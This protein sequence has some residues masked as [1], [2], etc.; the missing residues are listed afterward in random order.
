MKFINYIFLMICLTPQIIFS[1]QE[2]YISSLQEY[3]VAESTPVIQLQF[4]YN[5]L[6][7]YTVTGGS[8]ITGLSTSGSGAVVQGTGMAFLRTNSGS[9]VTGSAAI[10]ASKA[11]LSYQAGAGAEMLFSVIFG[12]GVTGNKQYVGIGNARDG[13]FFGYTGTSFGIL[14]EKNNQENWISQSSWN[15]DPVN[16][17]ISGTSA[18]NLIPEYG[19][20]YKIQYHWLGFGVI[21]F[22]VQNP[23]DGSW[24]LVH[25]IQYPSSTE[26]TG[27]SLSNP[28]LQLLAVNSNGSSTN[29]NVELKIPSMSAFIEG[30]QAGPEIYSRFSTG[31]ANS[32]TTTL[33]TFLSIRNNLTYNG[34]NNQ[35]MVFPDV[36]TLNNP[37]TTSPILVRLFIN[38]SV[39]GA[40]YTNIN[41]NSVVSF[42]TSRTG[43]TGNKEIM[44]IP[45]VG[46]SV[47]NRVL[48]MNLSDQKISLAPGDSLVVAVQSL[49]GTPT[50]AVGLSWYEKQ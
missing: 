38:P 37:S 11:R 23:T 22:Y 28:S 25:T 6:P 14:H 44:S 32:V 47:N 10:L 34:S 35:A 20:V 8:G 36:L 27:P 40:S 26:G 9:D 45:L 15:G 19:N 49:A 42:D 24:V 21:K 46:S 3:L 33:Q 5:L 18:F 41:T 16:T 31:V 39:S 13:F 4:V 43:I 48:N 29:S 7:D 12:T 50:V 17:G 30:Y 2:N 1:S